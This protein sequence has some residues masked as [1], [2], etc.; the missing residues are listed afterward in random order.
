MTYYLEALVIFFCSNGIF[1][2]GLNLQY[3]FTGILNFGYI[4]FYALGA[5]IAGVTQLGSQNA[6]IAKELQETF[7]LGADVRLPYPLPVV[8]AV[9]AGAV[10]A[11]IIGLILRRSLREDFTALA[12][13]AIFLGLYV[14]AGAYTPLFN[15]YNGIAGVTTPANMSSTDYMLVSLGW[16]LAATVFVLALTASP[17]GRLMKAVREQP[18]AAAALGKDVFRI[19]LSVF[20]VGNSLAALAGAVLVMYVNAWSPLSWQFAETLVAFSAVIVGGRGNNWGALAG[21]LLVGVV[22]NQATLFLP[23]I[24]SHPNLMPQLQWVIT[25]IVT[26]AFLWFRPQGL[27]PER[28]ITFGRRRQRRVLSP[29]EALVPVQQGGGGK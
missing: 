18:D 16:L 9:L 24:P 5:Y 22:I 1:A 20:I 4:L 8:A 17:F 12:S 25:G 6:G 29:A 13:V 28:K 11:S 10:L 23:Q 21:A 14:V 19:K 3:G 26:V 2:L 7:M 15:G 27:I